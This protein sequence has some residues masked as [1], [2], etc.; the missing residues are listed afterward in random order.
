MQLQQ[1]RYGS[2]FEGAL[3]ELQGPELEEATVDHPDKAG[4]LPTGTVCQV[5]PVSYS[6]LKFNE[7]V[8]AGPE[9]DRRVRRVVR[10]S[11]QSLYLSGGDRGLEKELGPVLRITSATF[12]DIPL[13]FALTP[14]FDNLK[15]WFHSF[16]S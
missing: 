3:A 10:A 13:Y 7:C 4:T 9:G 5:K 12:Q 6:E 11:A 2:E 1:Q 15:D 16:F 8:L 14:N